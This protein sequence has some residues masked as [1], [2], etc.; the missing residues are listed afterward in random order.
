MFV[1]QVA[2]FL[3]NRKGR[4]NDLSSALA[5]AKIDIITMTIAD[6]QDFGIVRLITVDNKRAVEVLKE[7]GFSVATSK[8]L[9]VELEDK[10]GALAAVLEVLT[11][12]DIDIEYMY[13]FA[14]TLGNKAIILFK[15]ADVEGAV[16]VLKEA[17]IKLIDTDID[18]SIG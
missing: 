12:G 5:K 15:V 4:L 11:K 1:N 7:E 10:V 16:K 8:L 9:G 6:T 2:V 13:S 17:N 3:E 18:K 14:R